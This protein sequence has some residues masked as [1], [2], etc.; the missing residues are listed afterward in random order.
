MLGQNICWGKSSHFW[1]V[2]DSPLVV[3]IGLNSGTN[4][5]NRSSDGLPVTQNNTENCDGSTDNMAKSQVSWEVKGC[6]A[7]YMFPDWK[8]STVADKNLYSYQ[9]PNNNREHN[10]TQGRFY[11][12]TFSMEFPWMCLAALIFLGEEKR[13]RWEQEWREN[14]SSCGIHICIWSECQRPSQGGLNS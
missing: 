7:S 6:H 5:V 11:S 10:R 1:N 4:G 13:E 9:A 2:P 3:L 14:R 8:G 12:W